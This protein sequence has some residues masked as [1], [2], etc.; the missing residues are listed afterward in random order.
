MRSLVAFGLCL[1]AV[2]GA[3]CNA[4][5]A[6]VGA[7]GG[8]L[9][10]GPLGAAAGAAAGYGYENS[11]R[12]ASTEATVASNSR[13]IDK[14]G[15]FVAGQVTKGRKSDLKPEQ[16]PVVAPKSNWRDVL[17]NNDGGLN[18]LGAE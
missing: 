12:I 16:V 6:V 11:Q 4:R 5:P 9:Y 14:V 1:I 13:D 8:L 15:D 7:V 3:G 2:V 18:L 17:S 10:A